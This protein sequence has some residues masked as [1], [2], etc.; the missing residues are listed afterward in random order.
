M[1]W[2]E[3]YDPDEI[4]YWD[5]YSYINS[6][7]EKLTDLK[8]QYIELMSEL[9]VCEQL[10]NETFYRKLKEIDSMGTIIIACKSIGGDSI[11]IVGSGTI[12]FEPKIIR[13]G[14]SVGH[15]E[16]IVVK[17]SY[18]GKKISQNILNELKEYAQ[19]KKC[20][21]VI[22]DCDEKVCPVYR[23][24]G[25]EINGVQMGLYF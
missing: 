22:L 4:L 19:I 18:R 25:F 13:G 7:I 6:H 16:D 15:I 23:T 2:G 10:D 21:K 5:F 3:G 8:N 20:Y 24:N 9:T 1:S 12:I 14:K 17:S 11:E